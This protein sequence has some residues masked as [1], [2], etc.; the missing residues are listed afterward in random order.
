MNDV[1]SPKGWL[2]LV[3]LLV[4]LS[5]I[6]LRHTRTLSLL[7]LGLVGLGSCTFAQ[8]IPTGSLDGE[9]RDASGAVLPGTSVTLTNVNTG[10]VRSVLTDGNGAYQFNLVPVGDHRLEA[11]LKGSK[12]YTQRITLEL[13]RKIRVNLRMEVGEVQQTVEVNTDGPVLETSS[14]SLSTSMNNRFVTELPLAGRNPLQLAVLSAGVVNTAPAVP[15]S[16]NDISNS[17]YFSANGA[18]QRMNEFLMDGVPNNVSDRVAYIPPV[19]QVQELNI[20]S[21][22]FHS[23]YGHSGGL[24]STFPPRAAV[25]T[26]TE[27]CMSSCATM[28]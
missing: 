9:V 10:E 19:D 3:D 24:T 7:C 2:F 15:S 27:A 22:S 8:V 13:G 6:F 11:E 20:Q 1:S 23:E 5:R 21:N 14:A 28:H 25:T 18:N 17:S 26:F 4:S 12:K 16:L